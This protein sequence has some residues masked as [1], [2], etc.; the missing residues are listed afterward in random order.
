MQ[1]AATVEADALTQAV[2]HGEDVVVAKRHFSRSTMHPALGAA[3]T[4]LDSEFIS[5]HFVRGVITTSSYSGVIHV[6]PLYM[7]RCGVTPVES[8]VHYFRPVFAVA[9]ADAPY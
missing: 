2:H 4:E 6:R 9:G 5:S 1:G 3:P 8:D 7:V